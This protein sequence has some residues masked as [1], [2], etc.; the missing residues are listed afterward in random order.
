L[1][2]TVVKLGSSWGQAGVKL[3]STWGQLG[4]NLGSSWG[5]A[6]VNL[7]STWVQHVPPYHRV[8][9]EGLSYGAHEV[10]TG[11]GY[12][13]GGAAAGHLGRH[14]GPGRGDL[15]LQPRE[16][17]RCVGPR[18]PFPDVLLIVNPYTL[19]ASSTSSVS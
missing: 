17:R 12:R 1:G 16:M 2:Q 3:G 15:V 4:V 19:A 18:H 14:A 10:G 9:H 11:G 6:G 7:G 8:A 5:Q 13:V